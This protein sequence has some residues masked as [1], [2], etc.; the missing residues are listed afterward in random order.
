M[1][2]SLALLLLAGCSDY[3]LEWKADG[4][5]GAQPAIEVEPTR[6]D[7]WDVGAGE[8]EVLSFEVHNVGQ[9]LLT[10]SGISSPALADFSLVYDGGTFAVEPGDSATVDVVFSPTVADEQTDAVVVASDDPERPT[11][12]VELVGEGRLPW[13]VVDPERHDFGAVEIPCPAEG[14]FVLQNVGGEDLEVSA[15]AVAGDDQVSIAEGPGTPFVLPPGAYTT[16]RVALAPAREGDVAA[17]LEVTSNDP[18]GV[19][20]AEIVAAPAWVGGGEDVFAVEDAPPVDVL[21]AVDQSAS[22]DDDAVS[23][24]ENFAAFVAAVEAETEGWQA[25]I[26]TYD[27]GCFNG[28]VLSAATNDLA[29]TVAVAT[30]LG[31]DRDIVD[32]EALFQIVDRALDQTGSGDC[33][34]G[35]LRAGALLHVVV[36]SDEPERS[37]EQASAWTWDW[38]VAAFEARVSAPS[39]LLIS[40]VVDVDGCGEGAENYAEAIAATGGEAL[41]ICSGDWAAH[42]AALAE[43]TTAGLW[44]YPLSAVPDPATLAVEVDGVAVATG[45]TWDEAGNAV[46]FDARPD[47]DEVVVRYSLA[48]SCG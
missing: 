44:S 37:P 27:D 23:L 16:V 12:P 42:V 29:G 18:R 3:A 33:N 46:V 21:F 8:T 9:A 30:S 47:G 6:L 48:G 11:V 43:A 14:E 5:G 45:W 17:A 1:R 4:A 20:T 13:L 26:A 38:W 39:R 10:V 41:S 24:A 22:M 15:V 25:G 7:F 34:E 32:D 19:V 2:C 31:D 35:F 40:G 28:G 36:V